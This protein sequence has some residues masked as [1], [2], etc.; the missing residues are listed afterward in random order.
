LILP[1]V[2][3]GYSYDTSCGEN[4]TPGIRARCDDI[5]CVPW[6]V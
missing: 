5:H 6:G 1:I 3:S 4:V 2:V